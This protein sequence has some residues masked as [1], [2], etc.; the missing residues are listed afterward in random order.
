MSEK[1]PGYAYNSTLRGPSKPMN[2]VNAKRRAKRES[3]GRVYGPHHDFVAT[4]PCVLAELHS[5]TCGFTSSQRSV[6][7][8]HLKT[9][10][11]GGEDWNNQVPVCALAHLEFHAAGSVSVMCD[12]Y[13]LDFRSIACEVTAAYA[14]EQ[15][16]P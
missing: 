6:C 15:D 12:R 13:G 8:H 4:L 14:A 7:G 5:H 2:K 1:K 9:V 11:T 10:K 3:E 16:E